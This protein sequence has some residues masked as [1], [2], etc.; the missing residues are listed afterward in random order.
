VLP[1]ERINHRKGILKRGNQYHMFAEI[2]PEEVMPD[3]RTQI[4]NV[5]MISA[6]LNYD[7]FPACD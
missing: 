1:V 4:L 6:Y 7:Y 2:E 5:N 3:R